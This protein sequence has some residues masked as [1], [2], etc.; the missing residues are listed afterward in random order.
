MPL[1]FPQQLLIIG[2]IDKTWLIENP[3]TLRIKF[4]H[5]KIGK[6]CHFAYFAPLLS[7]LLK[8]NIIQMLHFEYKNNKHKE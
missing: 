3:L 1:P 6:S 8:S 7:L 5:M 2:L 4:L